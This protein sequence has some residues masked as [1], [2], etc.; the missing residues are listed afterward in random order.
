MIRKHISSAFAG[1]MAMLLQIAAMSNASA[2]VFFHFWPDGDNIVM[3]D[4]FLPA[5]TWSNP[6]QV[7]LS[8]WNQVDTTDNTHPFRINL[9]PQFSF[10]AND[11]DNTMGFLGEAGLN[12]EYGLSYADAL[13]W[14]VCWSDSFSGLLDECDMMLNPALGWQLVPDSNNFFQSTVI[15][16][17]G[18]IRGLDHYNA[19]LATQNSGVDKILRGETLYMDD[20][21]GV[22]QNASHVAERD[23]VIYNKFHNGSV[24]TMSSTT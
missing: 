14:T 20:K 7:Q 9:N 19:Y 23:M 18:H 1:L 16:E 17:A 2:Y 22:R 6:A 5:A 10:G 15:H 3:D 21:E 4:V 13:A 8:E 24:P 11:G 12:S